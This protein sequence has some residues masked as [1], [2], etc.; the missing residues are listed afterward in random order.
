MQSL[1]IGTRS[2]EIGACV[3]MSLAPI[4]LAR[5]SYDPGL[6]TCGSPSQIFGILEFHTNAYSIP[7][8]INF[9]FN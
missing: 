1:E 2:W 7:N 5:V 8:A 3:P 6:P 4:C 9:L